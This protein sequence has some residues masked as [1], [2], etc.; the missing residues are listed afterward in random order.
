MAEFIAI[1]PSDFFNTLLYTGDGGTQ[2]ITGVG[3]TPNLTVIKN[4]TAGWQWVNWDTMNG[5]GDNTELS[6]NATNPIGGP[7]AYSYGQ[8]SVFGADGFT[9]AKGGSAG[10]PQFTNTSGTTYSS[11]NWKAGTTGTDL[12]AGTI[13]PSSSTISVAGGFGMYEYTGT[14]TN[15]TI[16]HGLGKT[17]AAIITK[18]VNVARDWACYHKNIGNTKY[19]KLNSD[20]AA[21]T[22]D[23]YWND[24]SPT[25]TVFSVSDGAEVNQS[26]GTYMAYVFAPIKGYSSFGSHQGH[27]G[28]VDGAYVYTGFRPNFIMFKNADGGDIWV[29]ENIKSGPINPVTKYLSPSNTTAETDSATMAVDF[30]S[31]GFKIR[32]TNNALNYTTQKILHWAWAEFPTVSSNDIPG[33]AR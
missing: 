7:D 10:T 6:W 3:F 12:S 17:P 15:A 18:Q 28:N 2:A 19:V 33:V 26:G 16:A 20:S 1:Q 29:A 22:A 11:Y 23:W 27:S 32:A 21:G 9:V 24:T 14:A 5:A 31:N 25:D 13:T 4:R 30:L 8:I